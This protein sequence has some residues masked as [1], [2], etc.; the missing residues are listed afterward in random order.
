[1]REPSKRRERRRRAARRGRFRDVAATAGRAA[2]AARCWMRPISASAHFTGIGLASTK[3]RRCS[4]SRR[5]LH[6]RAAREVAR[7]RRR[8]HLRHQLRRNVRGDRDH[9]VTAHQDQR[10]RIEVIAAVDREVALAGGLERAQE[11]A[12]ASDIRR[13]I[14]EADD[15]GH[16]RR[17]AAPSRSRDRRPCGPARCRESSAASTVSAIVRK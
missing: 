10:Q 14:L 17:D 16:V 8:A 13:R 4:G 9:A 7:E 3:R 5:S 12:H 15:A 1:M 6:A 2:A 11:L